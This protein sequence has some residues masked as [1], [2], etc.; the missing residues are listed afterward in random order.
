MVSQL[1]P[2]RITPGMLA[3]TNKGHFEFFPF[4]SEQGIQMPLTMMLKTL[5]SF[6]LQLYLHLARSHLLKMHREKSSHV[7]P[8]KWLLT[9]CAFWWT[10]WI[11]LVVKHDGDNSC[12]LLHM[13]FE[14]LDE[15]NILYFTIQKNLWFICQ[16]IKQDRGLVLLDSNQNSVNS[17]MGTWGQ[18]K[19]PFPKIPPLKLKWEEGPCKNASWPQFLAGQVNHLHPHAKTYFLAFTFST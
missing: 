8:V 9:S 4:L 17:M 16:E 2:Q 6:F 7:P 1:L 13:T 18:V 3:P 11:L 10:T 15:A 19:L 14:I 5:P 12:L